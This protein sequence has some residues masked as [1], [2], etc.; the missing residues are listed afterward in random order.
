MGPL[1]NKSSKRTL[2]TYSASRS[3]QLNI[4]DKHTDG[5]LQINKNKIKKAESFIVMESA[6][7]LF[8]MIFYSYGKFSCYIGGAALFVP[9]L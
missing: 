1:I 3:Q 6:K 8:K 2:Q 4:N 7:L 5:R 9:I